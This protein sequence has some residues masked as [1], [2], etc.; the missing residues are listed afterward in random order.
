M[1]TKMNTET[2]FPVAPTIHLNGSDAKTLSEGYQAAIEAVVEAIRAVS[3]TAPN[4]RDYYVQ[5]PGLINT[6]IAEHC[7]RVEVLQ[8]VRSEL[9]AVWEKVQAQVNRRDAWKASQ[10]VKPTHTCSRCGGTFFDVPL[11]VHTCPRENEAVIADHMNPFGDVV[12]AYTR[13]QAIEDGVLVDLNAVAGDVCRQHFKVPIACTAAV[14]AL[15]DKAVKSPKH[16]NDVAGVVHDILFM[17]KTGLAR[18]VDDS[19]RIFTVIITG[20]RKRNHQLKLVCG[21]GDNAEPVV[22]IMLPEE[23]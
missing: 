10:D 5:N 18:K 1:E 22:T 8:R 23:D 6:A 3:A 15:I 12:F 11:S 16:C 19:T 17:S 9:E 13:K 20:G 4:G 2:E 21:P 7:A 14:W